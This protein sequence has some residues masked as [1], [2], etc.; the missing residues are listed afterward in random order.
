MALHVVLNNICPPCP[1][2]PK[3]QLSKTVANWIV[4]PVGEKI[5]SKSGEHIGNRR[6]RMKYSIVLPLVL[7]FAF[8][9]LIIF[10]VN[11]L[12][13]TSDAGKIVIVLF[14]AMSSGWVFSSCFMLGPELCKELKHKE[15][16]SLL[17]IVSTL[18]SLGVGSSMGLGV[19]NAVTAWSSEERV[20][21]HKW[22]SHEKNGVWGSIGLRHHKH[23]R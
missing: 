14:F 1:R 8:Y 15:A 19:A 11:P 12:Y 21:V 6:P 9:P 13:F 18:V 16:A 5:M 7:R 20:R 17:L 23:I 4:N 22:S 10:C 3:V 2:S